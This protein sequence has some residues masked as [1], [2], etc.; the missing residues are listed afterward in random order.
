[1]GVL[2]EKKRGRKGGDLG[3]RAL[4]GKEG[5]K[6]EKEKGVVETVEEG[7]EER[8]RRGREKMRDLDLTDV[9]PMKRDF[10]AALYQHKNYPNYLCQSWYNAAKITHTNNR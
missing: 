10:F 3:E 4:R 6:E 7:G 5:W 8:R 2:R 1:M 9:I